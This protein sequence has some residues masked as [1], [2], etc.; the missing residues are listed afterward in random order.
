MRRLP[1]LAC[2]ALLHR[3]LFLRKPLVRRHVTTL[4]K[5]QRFVLLSS[6][7]H[8]PTPSLRSTSGA[9]S[10]GLAFGAV[11]TSGT[12]VL[13]VSWRHSAEN[14]EAEAEAEAEASF[15]YNWLR[16]N[17]PCPE[18]LHH[19]TFQRQV[20]TLQVEKA[21]PEFFFERSGGW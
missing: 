20:D 21:S 14:Q 12:G 19:Q 15:S 10:P 8:L 16:D 5:I 11:L 2:S 13:G 7:L 18:C 6:P 3:S 17:C 4:T 1:S 9:T